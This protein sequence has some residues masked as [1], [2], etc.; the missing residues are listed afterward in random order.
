MERKCAQFLIICKAD[1]YDIKITSGNRTQKEQET[2]YA[3]GRT[4][5]GRIVTKTL[6][7]KHIG[8]NAFDCAFKGNDPYPKFFDW[9]I[10]GEIGKS[11][12]LKWG[13]NFRSFRDVLH[14]EL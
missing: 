14:F 7:S 1:G 12:G 11:I 5:P 6:Q 4:I 9:R 13:G 8:G 2:L 10:I 3:Q